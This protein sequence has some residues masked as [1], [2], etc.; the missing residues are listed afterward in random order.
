SIPSLAMSHGI[1]STASSKSHF[2]S[3]KQTHYLA[4]VN[5]IM[6]G[7]IVIQYS[8]SPSRTTISS[9]MGPS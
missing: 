1:H 4:V 7:I 8:N 9:L 5:N 6:A 2:H 3:C